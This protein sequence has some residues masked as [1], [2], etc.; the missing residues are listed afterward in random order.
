MND[1]NDFGLVDDKM[2]FL[3][4]REEMFVGTVVGPVGIIV[5]FFVFNYKRLFVSPAD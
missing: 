5:E 4:G 3:E 2:I 1:W